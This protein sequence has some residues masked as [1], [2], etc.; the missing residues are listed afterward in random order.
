MTAGVAGDQEVTME[1]TT[2]KDQS[3]TDNQVKDENKMSE[4]S[5]TSTV[6]LAP[7]VPFSGSVL[8]DRDSKGNKQNTKSEEASLSVKLSLSATS[9]EKEPTMSA[10]KPRQV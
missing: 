9:N 3:L 4:E 1:A 6:S 7:D 10:T 2:E 5:A 8:L